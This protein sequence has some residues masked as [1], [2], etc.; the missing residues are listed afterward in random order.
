MTETEKPKMRKDD[1]LLSPKAVAEK[2]GLQKRE[3]Y[4]LISE[5]YFICYYPNGPGRR[6]VRVWESSVVAHIE[7]FSVKI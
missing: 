4:N 1:R 5:G 3:I 6:P 7:A 2:M